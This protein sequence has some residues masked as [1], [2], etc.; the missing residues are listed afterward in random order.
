VN[1]EDT[2]LQLCFDFRRVDLGGQGELA[3]ERAEEPLTVRPA[4]FLFLLL[5]PLLAANSEHAVLKAHFHVL[6][7]DAGELDVND[8][9]VVGLRH[10]AAGAPLKRDLATGPQPAEEVAAKDFVRNHAGEF[11]ERT[12]PL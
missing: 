9:L 6:R 4:L 7:V 11:L 8:D 3:L 10:V 2:F 12:P 1:F 5:G